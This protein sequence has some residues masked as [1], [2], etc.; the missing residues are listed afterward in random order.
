MLPVELGPCGGLQD[1]QLFPQV[2]RHAMVKI[3]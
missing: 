3:D 2:L 1:N